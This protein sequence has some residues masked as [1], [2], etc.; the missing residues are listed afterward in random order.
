MLT[1]PS[2]SPPGIDDGADVD[3]HLLAGMYERVRAQE[4]RAGGDHVTAV[5]KVEQTTIG[6]KPVSRLQGTRGG[7]GL[8]V[9]NAGRKIPVTGLDP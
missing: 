4:F 3:P 8:S 5:L 7:G 6:K 2:P 1:P 9:Q